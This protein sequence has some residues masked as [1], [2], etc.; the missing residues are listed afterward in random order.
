MSFF[1]KSGIV[2]VKMVITEE[3]ILSNIDKIQ[4]LINPNSKKQI[5]QLDEDAYFTKEKTNMFHNILDAYVM[6]E[7]ELYNAYNLDKP[8]AEIALDSQEVEPE[9][10]ETNDEEDD[11]ELFSGSTVVNG[12]S[13][14]IPGTA[15]QEIRDILNNLF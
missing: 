15:E 1:K 6:D 4:K 9:V 5:V 8:N 14:K 11:A 2:N 10:I 12:K 13:F 3:K 7:K